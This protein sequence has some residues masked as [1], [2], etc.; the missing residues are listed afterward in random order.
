M[1]QIFISHSRRDEQ[2]KNFFY[3]TFSGTAVLPIWMEYEDAPTSSIDQAIERRIHGSNAVFIL[4]SETVERI[5]FT[6][7]WILWENGKITNKDIWVFESEDSL[8]RINVVLPRFHHYVRYRRTKSWR[9]YINSIVRSYD[10]SNLVSLAGTGAGFGAVVSEENR[11]A[12]AIIGGLVGAVVEAM[13]RPNAPTGIP[14]S[15]L[16]CSYSYAIHLTRGINEFR[17]A[18]CHCRLE[19]RS[20]EF[21]PVNRIKWAY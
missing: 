11:A 10:S 3:R 9:D 2:T 14:V 18:R 5:P 6:R 15:C 4:L 20:Q 21:L 1:A 13:G 19:L 7:D 12:G 17:C 16:K 8:G